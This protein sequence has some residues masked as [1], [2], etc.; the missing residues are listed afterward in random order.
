VGSL[1]VASRLPDRL[2]GRREQAML[3]A[4]AEHVSLA[5]NDASARRTIDRALGDA[6]HQATHD[7]LTGLPN[8]SLALDRLEH[9]LARAGRSASSVAVLF[10][11]LDRFK[12]VN[13]S[14]GHGVGDELLIEVARRLTAGARSGDTVARLAG[15]EFVVICEDVEIRQALLLADRLSAVLAEPLSLYGRDSVQTASIGVALSDGTDRADELLRDA[16][17]AMYRAKEKGRSRIE[18]FDA[19]MRARMLQRI[20]TE[21]AL[22]RAIHAGEL[23]VDYQPIF[24]LTTQRPTGVEAL[25]RWQHPDGRLVPP[26][27]FI[28][29][30]EETGLIVA[31]GAWVLRQ[32]CADVARWR[33]DHPALA[34]IGVAVNLSGRQFGDPGLVQ[35]VTDVLAE[36]GLPPGAVTLEITETVLMEEAEATIETLLSLKSLGVRLSVDDFGTGYSSLSYLRRF[37]VDAL[38]IDRSF[39]QGLT[40]GTGDTAI[41]T[42]V[43]GLANALGLNVVAEGVEDA[44]QL[45]ELSNLGC[46]AAQGYLLGRPQP[47]ALAVAALTDCARVAA[48]FS[49]A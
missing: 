33:R 26:D 4:L 42:A 36:S 28:P 38:K 39:V 29:L 30:A 45:R 16:D 3:S 18:V 32:S 5:L 6:V 31:L 14:L 43:I 20:E 35:M 12:L 44:A 11:D 19:A 9:A 24:S 40:M 2:Y 21:Q 7:A 13:D 27:E 25:V 10:V 23:R 1:V 15:D 22:R 47:G 48:S 41:V 17:V 49:Y 46:D 37:P 34:D 8:R